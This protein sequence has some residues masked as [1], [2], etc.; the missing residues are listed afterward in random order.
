[1]HEV[2]RFDEPAWSSLLGWAPAGILI[3][4]G[5]RIRGQVA[6]R[7]GGPAPA[8]ARWRSSRSG[9]QPAAGPRGRLPA[10]DRPRFGLTDGGLRLR[11][12][13]DVPRPQR[14]MG[15]VCLP[16]GGSVVAGRDL[17]DGGRRRRRRRHLDPARHPHAGRHPRPEPR[18]VPPRPEAAAGEGVR[19]HVPHDRRRGVR[20]AR[21]G[22]PRRS[23]YRSSAPSGDAPGHCSRRGRPLRGGACADRAADG[24]PG[25]PQDRPVS[26]PDRA[27]RRIGIQ[28]TPVALV[29][30]GRGRAGGIGFARAANATGYCHREP[31]WPTNGI[32]QVPHLRVG[33]HPD[34]CIF[35]AAPGSAAVSRISPMPRSPVAGKSAWK[36]SASSWVTYRPDAEA[37]M[38]LCPRP[39]AGSPGTAAPARSSTVSG[40]ELRQVR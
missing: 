29:R 35:A 2:T 30:G 6:G 33:H 21:R 20:P 5:E 37:S 8:I 12:D 23:R 19:Q 28:G 16:A 38:R 32:G 10:R 4:K 7:P 9:G 34:G 22:L 1:M 3:E 39:V 26:L 15:R 27:R 17:D 31:G 14:R 18:H 24:G 36:P 13:V 25:L 11:H 40:A